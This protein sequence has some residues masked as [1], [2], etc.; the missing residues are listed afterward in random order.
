MCIWRS[1]VQHM[2]FVLR[3]VADC[4]KRYS[5]AS[6]LP[7]PCLQRIVGEW[8]QSG[9]EGVTKWFQSDYPLHVPENEYKRLFLGFE[10]GS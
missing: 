5:N 1:A 6:Q 7:P 9:K 4:G 2:L 8:A 3:Q 10:I